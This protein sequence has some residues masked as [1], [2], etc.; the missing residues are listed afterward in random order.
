MLNWNPGLS[1]TIHDDSGG[2]AFSLGNNVFGNTGIICCVWE[3][4]LLDDQV[5]INSNIK[6]SIF[7]RINYVFIL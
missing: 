7:N 3:P 1:L 5:V 4:G 6:I 2:G